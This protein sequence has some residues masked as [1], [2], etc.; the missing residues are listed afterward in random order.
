MREVEMRVRPEA[1]GDSHT[2][3]GNQLKWEQDG[4]WY[5]A[6]AFG[7]ES[8]AEVL[9]SSILLH[10][11]L[12]EPVRYE[13]VTV[14]YHEKRY[15]GCRSKNFKK[16]SERLIPVER[17]CRLH[18]GIGLAKTLERFSETADRIAYTVDLVT[19]ITGLAEFDRYLTQ[20]LEVDAFFLNE[21]RHTNNIALLYDEYT[22]AYRLCPFFD[23]GL[24]LFADT[25][26][27]YPLD[28]DYGD[29]MKKLQAKPFARD[30]DEQLDAA[31]G[32]CGCFLKFGWNAE[33]MCAELKR[34]ADEADY[35]SA[36]R[37]RAEWALR[38]QARKYAYM[39]P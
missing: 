1:L 27:D 16:P 32:R 23:M 21:D 20:L 37:R 31:N 7:Y 2:S 10:S 8:L 34:I 38:N 12:P 39:M 14:I 4:F 15:R 11:N 33:E 29:C 25:A 9:C 30:F 35:T 13:P 19:N 18:T 17:L 22:G 28:I 36:E 6:D 26:Q 5:K 24:S 3:K